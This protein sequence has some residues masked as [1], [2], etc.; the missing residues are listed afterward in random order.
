VG[1]SSKEARIV[2]TIL[3]SKPEAYFFFE[4]SM[5]SATYLKFNDTV[6]K[7]YIEVSASHILFYV[8]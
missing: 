5:I 6:F 3:K 1:A 4:F 2:S 7:Y 8:D